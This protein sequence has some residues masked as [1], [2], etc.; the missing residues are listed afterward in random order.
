ML[1]LLRSSMRRNFIISTPF[2]S[3]DSSWLLVGDIKALT[4]QTSLSHVLTTKAIDT[5]AKVVFLLPGFD[6]STI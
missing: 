1:D 2:P 5:K 3:R 6:P 4:R